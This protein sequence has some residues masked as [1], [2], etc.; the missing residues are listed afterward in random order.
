MFLSAAGVQA[1]RDD[2]GVHQ[3]L[4][5]AAPTFCGTQTY[6]GCTPSQKIVVTSKVEGFLGEQHALHNQAPDTA[7]AGAKVV[8]SLRK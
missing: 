3:E 5:T 4:Y 2:D 1:L 7:I 8:F 6:D